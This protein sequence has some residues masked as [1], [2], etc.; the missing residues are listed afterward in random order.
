MK[1]EEG[2]DWGLRIE[3]WG[4]R[5]GVKRA[6]FGGARDRLSNSTRNKNIVREQ[7][8]EKRE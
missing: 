7:R 3:G 2:N 4:R 5:V 8:V 1:K 6:F